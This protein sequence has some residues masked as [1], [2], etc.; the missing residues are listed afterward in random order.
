MKQNNSVIASTCHTA[1]GALAGV[2]VQRKVAST[3]YAEASL[4]RQA[5]LGG[6][7]GEQARARLIQQHYSWI[8]KRCLQTLRNEAEANDAAQEVALR[9]YRALPK[10][11]GRSSLCTWLNTIVHH[12]CVSAI[13]KRQRALLTAHLES[14]ITLYERDQ[15][16]TQS[17]LDI[18]LIAVH[19]ALDA[20]PSPAKEVL[21]LRFFS[22]LP[23]EEIGVILGISLS[24]TKM[25]LYRAMEQFKKIYRQFNDD[26]PVFA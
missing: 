12:E 15:R 3:E 25:R 20:L 13:R 10:F 22:E 16:T 5:R 23:L 7:L 18:P 14:L 24:A 21:Q 1:S 9:M 11:E 26:E 6:Y 8:R 4:V 17:G 19:E 2:P